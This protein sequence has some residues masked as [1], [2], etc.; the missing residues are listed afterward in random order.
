MIRPPDPVER[1]FEKQILWRF[2][3][4]WKEAA[5]EPYGRLAHGLSQRY[6]QL[7]SDETEERRVG[8]EC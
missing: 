5:R 2:H 7:P 6:D 8:K 3:L 1:F 4:G